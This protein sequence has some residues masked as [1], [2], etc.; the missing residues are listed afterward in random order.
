MGR[1][2]RFPSRQRRWNVLALNHQVDDPN[3]RKNDG[4]RDNG[5][6]EQTGSLHARSVDQSWTD[7]S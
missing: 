2:S 5:N 6:P 4:D 1:R 3:H 7:K